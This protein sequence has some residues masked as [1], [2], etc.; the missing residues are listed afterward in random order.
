MGQEDYKEHLISEAKKLGITPE[1]V[2]AIAFVESHYNPWAV[3]Y[4]PNWK[5]LYEVKQHARDLNVS[6]ETET[7]MQ[8][9]SWGMMQ[10]MGSVAREL[11][12]HG[13]LHQLAAPRLNAHYA[14]AKIYKLMQKY[15]L[16][17]DVV[18]AYNAGTP[19]KD[20]DGRYLNQGYVQLVVD[21]FNE[22]KKAN[23]RF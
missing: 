14:C 10:I 5:F 9:M 17:A 11:N 19:K 20:A 22:L 2:L 16:E 13:P 18:A 12:F 1:L 6:E 4:E 8:M 7:Q 21:K 15:I 3:R 23:R